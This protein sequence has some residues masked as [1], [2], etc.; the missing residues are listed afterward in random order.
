MQETS[1]NHKDD[2]AVSW[3]LDDAIQ[4]ATK[5]LNNDDNHPSKNCVIVMNG[6]HPESS[7]SPAV[8]SDVQAKTESSNEDNQGLIFVLFSRMIF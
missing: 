8:F 5:E 4:I 3:R 7:N 6:E 1:K 2:A